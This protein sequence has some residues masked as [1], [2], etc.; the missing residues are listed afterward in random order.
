M[1]SKQ[2][3]YKETI[4]IDGN[5]L[6]RS[7]IAGLTKEQR[8][9]LASK[10]FKY[11]RDLG[12]MYPDF[13][14]DYKKSYQKVIDY[15]PDINKNDIYNNVSL[16]TDICQY[17]C[18]KSYFN[19]TEKIRNKINPSFI[20]NFNN[21]DV[22]KKICLNRMGLS[23]FENEPLETFNLTPKM[24]MY[25]AQRSMRL[26][27]SISF[28]KPGIAK[29]IYLKY[30]NEKDVVYD[31]SAGFGARALGALSCDRKYIGIDPLTIPEIEEML[32]FLN[33]DKN[34]YCLIN[35]MSENYN[36]N[37]E[38]DLVFSSPPYYDQEYYSSDITQA[39]NKGEQYFYD[40]YWTNTIIN[41]KKIL[42]KDKYMVINLSDRYPKMLEIVVKIMG[43]YVDKVFLRTVRSHLNK[44]SKEDATK[45]EPIYVF[46]HQ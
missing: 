28:F 12:W 43:N 6:T 46:K 21:D 9:E 17:F 16:G 37:G 38:V 24:I 42:K 8:I 4:E 23:W 25:Q 39:Y 15:I 32:K 3:G 1:T 2:C 33:I 14:E 45:Y 20:D 35:D 27:P 34:N 18:R 26:V 10:L 11:L 7:Y 19:T 29:Y 36:F 41:S 30:S 31:F 13:D 40:V 5:K 22:L 44:T